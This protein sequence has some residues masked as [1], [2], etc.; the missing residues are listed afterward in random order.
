MQNLTQSQLKAIFTGTIK[1]WKELGGLDLTITP[2]IVDV[3]SAT[4]KAFRSVILEKED[5]ADCE[6]VSPDVDIL[7]KVAKNPDGIGHISYSFL[8]SSRNIK[9]IAVNGKY[10]P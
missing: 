5:Y 3:E 4:R 1:N 9:A 10:Y 6:A 8:D 2:Y 7:E